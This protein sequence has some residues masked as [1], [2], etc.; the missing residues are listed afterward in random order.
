[1]VNFRFHLVSLTAVFLALA[2]GI[3]IGAGVVDRQ[4]VDF[5]EDRLRTVENNRQQTNAENDRLRGDIDVW[6]R[7]GEQAGDGLIQGRLQEIPV[8]LVGVDGTER[9]LVERLRTSMQAA[10]AAVQGSVWLTGRWSLSN[11]DDVQRLAEVTGA[12][13]TTRP[14]DL[15]SGSWCRAGREELSTRSSR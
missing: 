9:E 13:A 8:L 14:N 6:R 3:A 12:S 10:G 5:L 15:R 1:M 7:F 2:A 4:T 11:S